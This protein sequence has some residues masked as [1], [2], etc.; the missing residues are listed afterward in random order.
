MQHINKLYRDYGPLY[1]IERFCPVDKA[2]FIDIETTGLQKESTSLYLI[3]CGHYTDEGFLTELFFA[4]SE[5]EE[6]MLMREFSS[7]VKDYTHMFHFNGMK[8]DVPYLLYKADQYGIEGL[9]DGIGQ[10][11]VYRLAAP[12][13]Q[14]LFPESMRQKA[15]ES[16]LK[17]DREDTFSGKELIDVYKR[18]EQ[19]H[20]DE[21]LDALITHNR[22]DVLGMH[23]IMPIMSYLDF[24]DA[25]IKY[26]GY[27]VNCYTDYNGNECSEVLF[28]Y[29]TSVSFPV[30]FVSKTESMFLKA[31]AD[32]GKITIRLPIYRT[33]MKLFYDNYRDYCYLPD[34]DMAILK[35]LTSSMPKNRYHKATKENCY[36]KMSGEFI[37]Q[38]ESLFTPVFRTEYKDKKKYFMFPDSFRKEAAEDFGRQLI[39]VFFK[40]KRR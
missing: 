1:P 40:M 31:S 23:L 30:S 2:L 36:R 18:Y 9:F 28:S 19:V 5:D 21:L 29:K 10:V 7:Y 4:D 3:G 13:R 6:E 16:F 22:E 11:D 25:D 20:D 33:E 27:K 15:I 32:S 14:L 38:P 37:K 8:F 26:E 24:M 12:L 17:I 39:N 35:E 34:E